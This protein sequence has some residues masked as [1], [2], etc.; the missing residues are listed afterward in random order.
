MRA[1]IMR[2]AIGLLAATLLPLSAAAAGEDAFIALQAA[3]RVERVS[4][5]PP[6]TEVREVV[7]THLAPAANARMLLALPAP[8]GGTR[9][10]DLENA[11]PV[12]QRVVLDPAAPGTLLIAHDGVTTRCAVWPGPA[13]A[14]AAA[15]RLAYVPVCDGRLSLRNAVPG[16][17][18]TLEATTEFLRDHVW[19]GEQIIGFVKREFYRDA[20]AERAAPAASASALAAAAPDAPPPAR[21]RDGAPQPAIVAGG[22]GI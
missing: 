2:T 17:R 12:G 16:N 18:S 13:L 9:S 20:F 19:R 21:P 8:G 5:P 15:M 3:R 1:R 11:D 7:L 4:L 6:S 10:F 14:Q 22:L